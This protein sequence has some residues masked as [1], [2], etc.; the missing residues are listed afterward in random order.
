VKNKG[1]MN[2][3]LHTKPDFEKKITDYLSEN[4]LFSVVNRTIKHDP[5]IEIPNKKIKNKTLRTTRP[6]K[7]ICL[8]RFL[9]LVSAPKK[10]L[11][12]VKP[13]HAPLLACKSLHH[14]L[15]PASFIFVPRNCTRRHRPKFY[16]VTNYC[17]PDVCAS[18]EPPATHINCTMSAKTRAM[19]RSLQP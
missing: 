10:I 6:I 14:D 16:T 19:L 18:I 15:V 11:L 17:C 5:Q 7:V 2:Y 3:S 12:R 13:R 4:Y 8:S 1:K 9:R